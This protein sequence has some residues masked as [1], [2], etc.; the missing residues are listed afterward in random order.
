[1]PLSVTDLDGSKRKNNNFGKMWPSSSRKKLRVLSNLAPIDKAP[2]LL[3]FDVETVERS[4]YI[5]DRD[6][7]HESGDKV[8]PSIFHSGGIDRRARDRSSDIFGFISCF[9][10]PV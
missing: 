4:N 9:H 5:V 10:D 6:E 7:A 1:M 8:E 2:F 3:S